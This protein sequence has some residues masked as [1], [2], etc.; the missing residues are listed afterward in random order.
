MHAPVLLEDRSSLDWPN[1]A[2]APKVGL[3]TRTARIEHHV[4]GT[5][6]IGDLVSQGDAVWAVE[7]RCPKTLMARTATSRVADHTIRWDDDD[8]D[9]PA[10][11]IPGVLAT[12]EIPFPDASVLHEVWHDASPVF[13]P[14]Y[15][16]VRGDARRVTPFRD[17][18]MSF[19]RDPEL[20]PGRMHVET[21]RSS[22]NLRFAVRAATDV[23]REAMEGEG[24]RS[25]WIA[26][27]IGVCG[28]FGRVFGSVDDGESGDGD[29][30]S[31]ALAEEIRTRLDDASVP[32]WEDPDLYDP[33]AAATAIE[34]FVFATPVMDA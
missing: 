17:S 7:L 9:G 31:D 26:A 33:A 20:S 3:G 19:Y 22:G 10:W 29:Q 32:S 28:H 27:L 8:I 4:E 30:T 25:V 23:Y 24:N 14:G 12:T 34:P 18:L 13:P 2:Y 1:T 15:W 11:L 21:D 16:I 5:D 6:L